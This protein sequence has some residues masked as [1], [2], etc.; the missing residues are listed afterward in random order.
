M[1]SVDRFHRRINGLIRQPGAGDRVHWATGLALGGQAHQPGH[2][3]TDGGDRGQGKPYAELFPTV[4]DP[5]MA[6][7][8]QAS[9]LNVYSPSA[10]SRATNELQPPLEDQQPWQFNFGAD[11]RMKYRCRRPM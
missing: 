11:Y 9:L 3:T 6:L 5:T 4:F 1:P 2:A 8:M 10:A 7:N